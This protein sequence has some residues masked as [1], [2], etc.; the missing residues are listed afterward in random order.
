GPDWSS[1]NSTVLNNLLGPSPTA[2]ALASQFPGK[3]VVLF[4]TGD[5]ATPTGGCGPGRGCS[6]ADWGY[7]IM[8]GFNTTFVCGH[9][10]IGLLA[11]ELGHY[12]ALAHTHA[13]E[14][15]NVDQADG[16]FMATRDRAAFDGDLGTASGTPPDP[17]AGVRQ[18]GTTI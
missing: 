15:K 13:R 17:F 4:R 6:G 10:N 11:H 14:F 5:P 16:F 1:T 12:F 2:L 3:L 18:C 9:Q 7:V 8:P